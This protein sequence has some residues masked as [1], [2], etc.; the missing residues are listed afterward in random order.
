MASTSLQCR[1]III[2][3]GGYFSGRCA[4]VQPAHH[5]VAGI[6]RTP[7]DAQPLRHRVITQEFLEFDLRPDRIVWVVRRPRPY[8]N[9]AALHKAYDELLGAVD[10]WLLERRIAARRLGTRQQTP[11]AWLYDLRNVRAHRNDDAFEKAIQRRQPDLLSRSPFMAV[12]VR[13]A[14][15]RAQ[16]HRLRRAQNQG[17]P[18]VFDDEDAALAWLLEKV[19]QAF[20]GES[21]W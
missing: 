16:M 4:H 7:A 21:G 12:L 11:M 20:P 13:T 2:A 17:D 18:E 9:V 1:A 8:D 3:G 5:N 10:S 15:G 6:M 19:A 14:V